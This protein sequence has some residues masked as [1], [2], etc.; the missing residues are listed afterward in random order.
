MRASLVAVTCVV[1][2]LTT[3]ASAQDAPRRGGG[4]GRPPAAGQPAQ[5]VLSPERAKAAWEA[6]V[7]AATAD[8]RLT[9]DQ[10]K[11]VNKAYADARTALNDASEQIRREARQRASDGDQARTREVM[12]EIQEKI[13]KAADDQRT[14]LRKALA[15]TLTSGQTDRAL[16]SLGTFNPQW[17]RM[18]DS[19]NQFRLDASKG[20]KAHG[21]VKE[22]VVALA[23]IR[24]AGDR[25]RARE[26]MQNARAK[27]TAALKDVL[28]DEQFAEFEQTMAPGRRPDASPGEGRPGRGGGDDGRG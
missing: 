9:D 3:V 20:G 8:M 24:D 11:I 1:G 10:L 21:A 4:E 22:Y 12:A 28:S 6:Q 27:L 16:E 13:R 26:D 15:E 18:A 17:D 7:K 25:E 23:K 2:L 14:V 5:P 19:L